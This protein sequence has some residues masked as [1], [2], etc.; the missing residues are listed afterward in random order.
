MTEPFLKWPGGKRW[1]VKKHSLIFPTEY[2]RYVEP[3]LGSGAVYFHLAPR[4]AILSDRNPDLINLYACIKRDAE[5]IQ[6]RLE[7]LQKLHG[8]ALYYKVRASV[9]LDPMERAIR[10]IYLNRTCFNGIYRVNLKGEFNV[11]MGSKTLV[12]YPPDYLRQ[13]S[14]QLR[15]ASVRHA[16]FERTLADTRSGDFVFID[17]PYTVAHNFNNFVKYNATLFSW[18]DQERLAVA[19]KSASRRGAAVML[20]NADHRSVR[21]L[22]HGFG[23]KYQISR[24]SILAANS[25][26]R[27]QTTELLI[28]NFEIQQLRNC[29]KADGTV[30]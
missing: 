1:L 2:Q 19:V 25:S 6:R 16:D 26:H 13:V 8:A 4:R 29:Q 30:D 11:P 22:Y 20:S 9:P 10:L 5:F 28:T 15:N 3:F 23:Y 18:R 21:G 12:K 24:S 27:R 7:H 17:P 14:R